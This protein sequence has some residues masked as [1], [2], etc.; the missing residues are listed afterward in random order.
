M[1]HSTQNY[2]ESGKTGFPQLI[3]IYIFVY[4]YNVLYIFR[5]IIYIFFSK[6]AKLSNFIFLNGKLA[7]FD[8]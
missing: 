4:V 3:Y 7:I 8:R 5:Y 1:G 2:V 6:P